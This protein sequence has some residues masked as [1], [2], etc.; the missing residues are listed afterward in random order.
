MY[1]FYNYSII[2]F[3]IVCRY[4]NPK[5]K[6]LFQK[7]QGPKTGE[8]VQICGESAQILVCLSTAHRTPHTA[9]RNDSHVHMCFANY[10]QYSGVGCGC[11]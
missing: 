7:K 5:T 1:F 10:V 9:H 2:S 4:I 6:M 3:F 8:S 11:G